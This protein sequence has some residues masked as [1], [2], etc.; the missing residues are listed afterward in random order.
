MGLALRGT[1]P[2]VPMDL[3][4]I[5]ALVSNIACVLHSFSY[6]GKSCEEP[7]QSLR[8]AILLHA[9]PCA[10]GIMNYNET[11]VDCGGPLCLPCDRG[12]VGVHVL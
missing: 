7:C 4:M 6:L 10:D 5:Y 12:Q 2:M 1:S 8:A 3:A 11:D 9:D